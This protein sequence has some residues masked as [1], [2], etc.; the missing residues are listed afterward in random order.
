MRLSMPYPILFAVISAL[1][2]HV[3]SLP[4]EEVSPFNFVTEHHPSPD[5]IQKSR[6]LDSS[7]IAHGFEND[8]QSVQEPGQV[9]SL[10]SSN[11]F[12]NFCATVPNLPIT[13]GKQITT[14]SCNPAPMGIIPSTDNI[15][16]AKFQFPINFAQIPPNQSFNISL[17]IRGM[18]T[19]HFVNAQQNYY[20]APQQVNSNGQVI[21][22]THIVIE[23]L[24][25]FRQTTPTDPTKFAFFKGVNAPATN[26]VLT[27]DVTA[28]LPAG[29]FRISTINAAA[30]HQPILAPIAQR[31]SIDDVVYFAVQA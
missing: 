5:D 17:A 16:S 24:S 26:G 6:E 23:Q 20:A 28:G 7:V 2:H 22:H 27:V 31:G 30:N 10:T 1:I 13:N 15:P 18:E 4:T 8:G 19:G 21:G 29:V 11:N 9:P 14:G 3:V 25:S 12:I